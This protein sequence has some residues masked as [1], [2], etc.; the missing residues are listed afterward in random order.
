MEAKLLNLPQCSQI[1][2]T[3]REFTPQAATSGCLVPHVRC[4]YMRIN[5]VSLVL[6]GWWQF[7]IWRKWL[8]LINR[9][10]MMAASFIRMNQTF[11]HVLVDMKTSWQKLGDTSQR[12]NLRRKD[13]KIKQVF[14]IYFEAKASIRFYFLS[15]SVVEKI[16]PLLFPV[17]FSLYF[18]IS[19]RIK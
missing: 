7:L 2:C 10:Q 14:V 13:S 3:I 19:G 5:H 15:F 16:H 17:L 12:L 18:M 9:I 1:S 4:N 6:G 8:L 11:L